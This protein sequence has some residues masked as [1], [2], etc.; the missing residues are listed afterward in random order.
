MGVGHPL[1]VLNLEFRTIK[2]NQEESI[3]MELEK[4]KLQIANSI[5]CLDHFPPAP[6][7]RFCT[8]GAENSGPSDLPGH[9]CN[10]S[11]GSNRLERRG[12]SCLVVVG[13]CRSLSVVVGR[14]WS[15]L[16]VVGQPYPIV[17]V[18]SR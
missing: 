8:E 7:L 12:A 14:C 6:R 13:R 5:P 16:V 9:C 4:K 1:S 17:F 3:K 10:G 11:N 18:V 15:L 2:N